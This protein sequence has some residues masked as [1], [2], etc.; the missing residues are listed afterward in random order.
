MRS[1]RPLVPVLVLLGLVVAIVSSL[2][3][4]SS[5]PIATE[6]GVCLATA[7]WSL[8]SGPLVGAIATPVMGRLGD[9]PRR[10]EVVLVTLVVAAV[11]STLAALPLPFGWLVVGSSTLRRSGSGARSPARLAAS[12]GDDTHDR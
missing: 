9:G 7:Q 8:T 12:A 3:A 10:C 4:P 6:T 1:S 11:G 5:P 2:G